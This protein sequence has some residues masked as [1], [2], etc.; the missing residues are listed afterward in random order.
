M[1]GLLS[2]L[3][4]PA[5]LL[6]IAVSLSLSPA[7]AR[8]QDDRE[9]CNRD[10]AERINQVRDQ[11]LGNRVSRWDYD[12][13]GRLRNSWLNVKG[14]SVAASGITDTM[15]DADF[16]SA[17]LEPAILSPSDHAKIG[18]AAM[19]LEPLTWTAT[20]NAAQQIGDRTIYLDGQ[21][22]T[23]RSYAFAGGRRT[24]DGKWISTFNQSGRLT[25]LESTDAGRKIEYIWD[26]NLRLVGRNAYK[27]DSGNNWVAE[28]RTEVL[29]KD[30]LPANVTLVWD[31]IVDRLL[32]I[33]AAG[34][35]TVSG[36]GPEA[37]LLRQYLHGDQGYDDPI[38]VLVAGQSGVSTYFPLVDKSGSGS[39]QAV[40]DGSGTMVERVLYADS[41]GDAPRYL[42]GPVVDRIALSGSKD[43]N[44][45]LDAV[46]VR[47]HL[48][49]AIDST[50][51]SS[52]ARLAAVDNA[53][54]V[55]YQ[56]NVVPT[57]DD[58]YTIHWSLTRTEWDQ[59]A[60]AGGASLEIAVRGSLRAT[61]WGNT[62]VSA[63][64]EWAVK[65]YGADRTADSPVTTR[66]SFADVTAFFNGI[67][68]NATRSTDLYAISSLYMAGTQ[69]SKSKLLF[70]FHALPFHDP[71]SGVIYARA[72]WYDPATG[73]FLTPDPKGFDDSSNLY[74]YCA[75]DPI[76]SEDPSGE[77]SLK[78]LL[79][80]GGGDY[81][82]KG[83]A[84]NK[85]KGYGMV[86]AYSVLHTVT[87]GF[88]SRHD[89]YYDAYERGEISGAEY[90]QQGIGVSAARSAIIFAAAVA[91]GG[92]GAGVAEGLGV[93]TQVTF[94]VAGGSAGFGGTLATDVVDV[95]IL[96]DREH[97][98][99]PG[100]YALSIAIGAAGGYLTASVADV[101]ANAYQKGLAGEEQVSESIEIPRNA[102]A[103]R[104]R[105]AIPGQK[106]PTGRQAYTIPD[107]PPSRT[108]PQRSAVVD[109]KNVAELDAAD[110]NIPALRQVAAARG[111]P[112][113]LHVRQ[114]TPF[115]TP[116]RIAPGTRPLLGNGPGDIVVVR[117]IDPLNGA[118]PPI[119][120]VVMPAQKK[121][122]P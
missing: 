100:T 46:D 118:R 60:N 82:D 107:F 25:S 23:V 8:T 59:L 41:Y 14:P 93:S 40:V 119:V 62:P 36:A 7:T 45:D 2:F 78:R 17:R 109:A 48:S 18:T 1:K 6:I 97:Y 91:T 73:A 4:V 117:T 81:I 85:A 15:I 89:D 67:S 33:Y 86:F 114:G 42:Q 83:G 58:Q 39:L 90:V 21:P 55:V 69:E 9:N 11:G 77:E 57:L 112:L 63:A 75:G 110:G 66:Q 28:D 120:P 95:N 84:L 106:T 52:G 108:V 92:F 38:R 96:H 116:T 30:G 74:A 35:S 71:A 20:K 49:E 79:V 12:D 102:G 87:V 3:V 37:G 24:S 68:A 47:I 10:A 44:G 64:P 43:G 26:P 103:G 54:N 99:P 101:P 50:T 72:R 65:V 113:E 56:T 5:L 32:A 51:V 115:S 13:R 19:E 53:R 16:R 34:K 61:A 122:G 29:D 70:D 121:K 105:F 31:P 76:N 111:V 104:E 22:S 98:S 94:A 80:E 27:L 88:A